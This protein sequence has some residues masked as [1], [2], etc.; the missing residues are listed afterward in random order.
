MRLKLDSHLLDWLVVVGA[1]LIFVTLEHALPP[2]HQLFYIDDR[3]FAY[4]FAQHEQVPVWLLILLAYVFPGAVILIG[5]VAFDFSR[6]RSTAL[7]PLQGGAN[8]GGGYTAVSKDSD[9]L[10]SYTGIGTGTGSSRSTRQ[11]TSDMSEQTFVASTPGRRRTPP[12][13]GLTPG[14]IPHDSHYLATHPV[15]AL[16]RGSRLRRL[17]HA[18]LLALSA[19]TALTVFAT[20]VLKNGVGRPRPD[21]LSRCM[22]RD[23][24]P[25]DVPVSID[26]CQ[27]VASSGGAHKVTSDDSTAKRFAD[28]LADALSMSTAKVGSSA[29]TASVSNTASQAT[30]RSRK[31]LLDEGFRSFPSGHSSYAFAGLGFLSLWLMGQLSLFAVPHTYHYAATTPPSASSSVSVQR[32]LRLWRSFLSLTPLWLAVYI[33]VSRIQDHRHHVSDVV[34]GA[35]LGLAGSYLAYR[36]YFPP[37][38]APQGVT[39]LSLDEIVDPGHVHANQGNNGGGGERLRGQLAAD[40]V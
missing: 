2:H 1:L 12:K 17:L 32:P 14:D 36:L 40:V 24:T 25:T 13:R 10:D 5:S 26:V 29:S 15:P 39:W 19:S 27:I 28:A 22:P 11:Q 30:A 21:M 33:A 16:E 4:P 18:S 7:L 38:D 9:D 3:Q 35:L 6:P 34:V 31:K 23:G 37:L 8:G 20:S